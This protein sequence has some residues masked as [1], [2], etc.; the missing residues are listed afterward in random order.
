MIR[1]QTR[2]LVIYYSTFVRCKVYKN[3]DTTERANELYCYC[4]QLTDQI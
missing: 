1:I 2:V 3:F 4:Q